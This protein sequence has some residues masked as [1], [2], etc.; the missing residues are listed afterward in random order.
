[1]GK[2]IGNL[3]PFEIE[4]KIG[5]KLRITK[6]NNYAFGY[7]EQYLKN[8]NVE[9]STEEILEEIGKK[10]FRSIKAIL[11][12]AIKSSNNEYCASQFQK[13]FNF[14]EVKNYIDVVIK[15]IENYLPDGKE[16]TKK[17]PNK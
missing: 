17:S 11:F 9:L 8:D 13:D 1:M 15:G 7:A 16:S 5:G 14:E 4:V 2:Q 10:K 6:W 12:G 3:I